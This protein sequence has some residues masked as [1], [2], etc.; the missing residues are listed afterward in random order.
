MLIDTHA[1]LDMQEFDQDR[2][3]VLK[4]AKNSGLTHVITVGI[5]LTAS[6]NGMDLADKHACVFAAVGCHPHHAG[7]CDR[8]TLDR[9]AQ[10]ASRPKAVAWGEIGLDFYRNL[11]PPDVQRECFQLQLERANDLG[12]PVVIH[13][14]EAHGEVLAMLRRVGKRNGAGV[15]HCFSGDPGLA[16]EFIHLGYSISIAG[17]VTYPKATRVQEVAASIPLDAMVLETDAPFLSPVPKRGK[18]NEPG[19]V[20]FTAR[21]V[22]RLRKMDL[23]EVA[24]FT[25]RNAMA[26]FSIPEVP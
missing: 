16:L 18:R 26:L 24:R 5:D 1:H 3:D 7:T 19:F 17:T 9:L 8:K 23:E 15:I 22:A 25:S 20:T 11:A 14:R 10:L 21:E 2:D 6:C 12:L 13:D 4:R